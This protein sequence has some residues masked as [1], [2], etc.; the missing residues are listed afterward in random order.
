MKNKLTI[1]ECEIISEVIDVLYEDG[2]MMDTF[3]GIYTEKEI[4][5]TFWKV[6]AILNELNNEKQ[7]TLKR[8][9]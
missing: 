2:Y 3:K 4:D 1:K 6:Q 5:K 9:H 8:N 7:K